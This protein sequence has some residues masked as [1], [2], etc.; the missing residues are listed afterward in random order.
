GRLSA[1]PVQ[2]RMSPPCLGRDALDVRCMLAR[3]ATASIDTI[4]TSDTS[5]GIFTQSAI[6]IL[7]SMKA[8]QVRSVP[9]FA[10]GGEG[11][12]EQHR[13]ALGQ[14]RDQ[15]CAHVGSGLLAQALSE[16]VEFARDELR[17]LVGEP[18]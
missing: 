4:T 13:D 7:V 8:R 9:R 6:G 11:F 14:G 12:F 15:G 18:V 16:A 10:R 5:T 1:A 17:Q 3:I 2:V